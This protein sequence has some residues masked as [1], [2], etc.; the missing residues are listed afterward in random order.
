MHEMGPWENLI[1]DRAEATVLLLPRWPGILMFRP[2]R[3]LT[4]LQMEL[5]DVNIFTCHASIGSLIR[6]SGR[7]FVQPFALF[8]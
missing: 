7:A 5:G 2:T 3:V 8:A 1:V 6:F 4:L